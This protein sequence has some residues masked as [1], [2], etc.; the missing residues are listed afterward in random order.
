MIDDDADAAAVDDDAVTAAGDNDD[1]EDDDED[2]Q[3]GDENDDEDEDDEDEED[4]RSL[5]PASSVDACRWLAAGVLAACASSVGCPGGSL[6]EP[7]AWPS[8]RKT[9]AGLL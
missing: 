4:Q 3:D 5:A 1:D 2:D 7:P 8:P 9:H 6:T